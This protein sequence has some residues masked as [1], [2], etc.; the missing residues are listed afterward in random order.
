MTNA[1][2]SSGTVV[3]VAKFVVDACE[4]IPN[5]K[6]GYQRYDEI[7]VEREIFSVKQSTSEVIATLLEFFK[8]FPLMPIEPFR[9]VFG[10]CI[11]MQMSGSKRDNVLMTICLLLPSQTVQTLAYFFQFLKDVILENCHDN[12]MTIDP[13]SNMVLDT[14]PLDDLTPVDRMECKLIIQLL[15]LNADQIGMI[16]SYEESECDYKS[17]RII[18]FCEQP[19]FIQEKP[20]G[21]MKRTYS[22][23]KM[24]WKRPSAEKKHENP[25]TDR[26]T[27]NK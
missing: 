15:I 23:V 7:H 22:R 10:E 4:S 3:A 9:L 26:I 17:D 5:L 19:S 13:L 1:Y 27:E 6:R 18:T 8:I 25:E 14:I 21:I 2:L 24:L 20:I 12:R 16:P 11:R